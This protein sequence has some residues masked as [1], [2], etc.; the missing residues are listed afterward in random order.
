[1]PQGR[2]R[3]SAECVFTC[4]LR[5]SLRLKL[6]LHTEQEKGFSPVWMIWCWWRWLGFLKTFQQSGQAKGPSPPPATGGGAPTP[7][8]AAGAAF[9][10]AEAAGAA[11][12]AG[13]PEGAEV[14][15]AAGALAAGAG[16]PS[17]GRG[18]PGCG[19]PP[20]AG[21]TSLWQRRWRMRLETW[22]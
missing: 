1:M 19:G 14:G 10:S 3:R 20:A 22:L 12:V 8:G 18:A 5:L 16:S 15:A 17:G 13:G 2:R 4:R 21:G 9:A 11:G 6:L 7:A